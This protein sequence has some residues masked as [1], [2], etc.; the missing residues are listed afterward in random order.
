MASTGVKK[1]VIEDAGCQAGIFDVCCRFLSTNDSALAKDI[2]VLLSGYFFGHLKDHLYQS[3]VGKTLRSVEQHAGVAEII[4]CAFVPGPQVFYSVTDRG[5]QFEPPRARHPSGLL[6][7]RTAAPWGR[8]P[9]AH[10]FHTLG[11][12]HGLP[13][14]LVLCGAEQ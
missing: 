10:M 3:I 9:Q 13:V 5:V 12:L 14:V 1:F 11:A 7:V 8:S 4:D 6:G 2:A